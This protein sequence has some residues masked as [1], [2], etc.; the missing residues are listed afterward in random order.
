MSISAVRS[1]ARDPIAVLCDDLRGRLASGQRFAALLGRGDPAVGTGLT[2]LVAHDGGVTP[3]RA[4]LPAGVTHYPAL[5]PQLP[6]AFW[7][8]RAIHDL[9]GLVPDGHPRLDPLVLPH[10][11]D[12]SP[13]P[14]PGAPGQPDRIE[15]D[16][17]ALSALLHGTGVFTIPHGPV[18][19]GVFESVE[20][21]VETPGEDIPNLRIRPHAKHR[22]VQKRFEGR[23]VEDGVLLAERVEGIASVAHALAFAHAVEALADA[24]VPV[25]AALIRV[26]HAELERIANHLDVLGKLTDAAGLAVA[27]ARFGLHKEHTLRLVGALSGSR[28]GRGVVVPGGV[29]ALPLLPADEITTELDRLQHAIDGDVRALLATSSFLDRVRT[30]GPLDP[31]LARTHGALGPIGR[32]A[33]YADDARVTRP[34]DG[35]QQLAPPP[36]PVRDAGDAQARMQVRIDEIDTAFHLAHHAVG[37]LPDCEP[38]RLRVV[39]Q[40]GAGLAVGWA[41]A[42]Q[43]EVLYLLELGDDGRIGYCAPRSASFHNLM[44]FPSTFV[45]DILT[46]FPFNEASFGLSIAG[47]VM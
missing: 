45:G 46:D 25:A 38:E 43:G 41:E 37:R 28:F 10:R 33:G 47:V 31:E 7:Y 6:A 42:P 32:G 13:L 39:A 16:E 18:R 44:L 17:Q 22:G 12:G 40:P 15:P 1:F 5:T 27:S 11:N 2:A 20:Y 26:L 3:L 4:T 8:E 36:V 23:T 35:Y 30:A 21:L 9:V 19:S 14:H 29:T 34:Y 24:R